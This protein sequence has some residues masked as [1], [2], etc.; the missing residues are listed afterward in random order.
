MTSNNNKDKPVFPQLKPHADNFA[1]EVA[2]EF[3]NDGRTKNVFSPDGVDKNTR[4]S[5][6]SQMSGVPIY[7]KSENKKKD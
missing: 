7:T 5:V 6:E 3:G 1:S 2:K 4:M